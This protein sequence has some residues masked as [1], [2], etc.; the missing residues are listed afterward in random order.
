LLVTMPHQ[1]I[2]Y[3]ICF[4]IFVL[5]YNKLIKDKYFKTK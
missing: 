5:N 3:F 4:K 1:C 2:L